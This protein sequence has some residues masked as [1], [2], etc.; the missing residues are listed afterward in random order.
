MLSLNSY[1]Q[2]FRTLDE[3]LLFY[4]LS[5]SILECPVFDIHNNQ[6]YF[7]CPDLFKLQRLL[8]DTS[9]YLLTLLSNVAEAQPLYAANM[10]HYDVMKGIEI[11]D[12]KAIC[13]HKEATL[14]PSSSSS[15]T[16]FPSS[17]ASSTSSTL[18]VPSLLLSIIQ[19]ETQEFLTEI[20]KADTDIENRK[21]T[22]HGTALTTGNNLEFNGSKISASPS[23]TGIPL[24]LKS[25]GEDSSPSTRNVLLKS[26]QESLNI[27]GNCNSNSPNNS[28]DSKNDGR[29]YSS[30]KERNVIDEEKDSN[31]TVEEGEK[32][33]KRGKGEKLPV[34]ELILASH[35]SLLLHALCVCLPETLDTNNVR[36][37]TKNVHIESDKQCKK[38]INEFPPLKIQK[39]IHGEHTGDNIGASSTSTSL[40]LGTN[41]KMD[42]D[43]GE[44]PYKD[45]SAV[46]IPC[47][48]S[49]SCVRQCLP[50][51]T[52][53]LPIRVLKGFLVLQ[54]QVRIVCDV[55]VWCMIV[56]CVMCDL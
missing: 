11:C 30:P 54:G 27:D 13:P 56:C 24:L 34:A 29:S 55:I 5:C 23:K 6:T 35:A 47:K 19:K 37:S 45:M 17:S 39:H 22:S 48:I 26:S 7:S 9:L 41:L 2:F 12:L 32:T 31:S 16:S 42:R 46:Q 43:G 44:N 40:E 1:V 3:S 50:K 20:E 28:N 15:S 25:S 49:R 36:T 51:G 18:L 8:F 38:G 4:I 14:K 10:A 33:E 21:N 52:W 53:W